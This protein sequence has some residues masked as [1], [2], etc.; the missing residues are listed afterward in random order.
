M[1]TF[2]SDKQIINIKTLLNIKMDS[3]VFIPGEHYKNSTKT[4][5]FLYEICKFEQNFFKDENL[6]I[7]ILAIKSSTYYNKYIA[8]KLEVTVFLK[9]FFYY[10]YIIYTIYILVQ[11]FGINF[12]V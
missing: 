10:I 7:S 2:L 4:F 5:F 3:K 9:I 1:K 11:K 8:N 12:F 6:L